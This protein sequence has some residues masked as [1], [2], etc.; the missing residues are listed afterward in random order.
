[1]YKSEFMYE[2]SIGIEMTRVVKQVGAILRI[3]YER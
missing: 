1:M 2:G 3:N